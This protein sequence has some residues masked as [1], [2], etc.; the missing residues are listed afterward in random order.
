MTGLKNKVAVVTGAG[1]GIGRAAAEL[2]AREGAGVVLA[3]IDEKL[4]GA[5]E[6]SIR[7][8]GGEAVF[9]RTDISSTEDVVQVFAEAKRLFR[10]LHVLYNNAS[11][12][13]GKDDAPL[14]DLSEQAWDRTLA[15][16]LRGLF[17]CCKYGIPL[18]IQSGG[19]SVINTSS[20]AGIM[21]IPGCDAYTATKGA[22]I[23]LTRSMAVEYGPSGVRVNCIAPAGVD[24]EMLRESSLDNPDFDEDGF[25][26]RAPLGR[27][28][29]PEEIARVA[30]FLASD[31]SSYVNGA[32]IRAEG[33]I[34]I[35]PIG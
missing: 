27:Y 34:T 32:I 20:S 16:N 28:G 3:E 6:R 30:L 23:S 17:L 18:I 13:L 2:F 5:V 14:T 22:T 7:D 29:E 11:I 25:L 1:R 9:V 24:T 31:E 26:D 8:A 4:G 12:F 19:G 21:G 10:G 33:G 15:V 35:T